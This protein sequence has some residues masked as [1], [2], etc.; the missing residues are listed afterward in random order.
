MQCQLGRVEYGYHHI[1]IDWIDPWD[2][3][4]NRPPLKPLVGPNRRLVP[5]LVTG[6]STRIG[7]DWHDICQSA[8]NWCQS[9]YYKWRWFVCVV[10]G[11][12]VWRWGLRLE[13]C[14]LMGLDW[15]IG[16]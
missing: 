2:A 3:F 5:L 10:M 8:A 4:A 6:L 1:D 13:V 11:V 14:S 9:I 15:K 7:A 12:S 16:Q